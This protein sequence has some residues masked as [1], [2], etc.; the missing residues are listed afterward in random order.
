M[1]VFVAFVVGAVVGF[2]G[3]F[4]F[5]RNNAKRLAQ[6]EVELRAQLKVAEDVIAGFKKKKSTTK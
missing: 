5:S 3:G 6:T 1:S 4:L 2:I